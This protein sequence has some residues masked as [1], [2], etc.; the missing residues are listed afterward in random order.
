MASN[1][2]DPRRLVAVLGSKLTLRGFPVTADDIRK[3]LEVLSGLPPDVDLETVGRVLAGVYSRDEKMYR[4]FMR[5]WHS[6]FSEERGAE[7][8][9]GKS[10]G[11]ATGSLEEVLAERLLSRIKERMERESLAPISTDTILR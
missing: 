5:I 3:A 1:L 10:L 8:G 2:R 6:M 7:K 4:E 9:T 11:P